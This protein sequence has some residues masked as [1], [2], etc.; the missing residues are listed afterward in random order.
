MDRNLTFGLLTA[1]AIHGGLFFGM[2]RGAA[3]VKP[4]KER[5]EAIDLIPQR[6]APDDPIEVPPD[7]AQPKGDPNAYKP[8]ID[9]VAVV[10][11]ITEFTQPVTVAP[12]VNFEQL[13]EIRPGA[14]GVRD[15]SET[16]IR[17]TVLPAG[18]LDKS[19]RT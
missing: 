12:P 2:P 16:I 1:A 18:L 11:K 9:D 19:P 14:L 5:L 4:L 17:P 15:G 6:L 3:P 7:D 10:A 8:V 13:K